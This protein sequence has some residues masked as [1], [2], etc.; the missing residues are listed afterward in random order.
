MAAG[1]PPRKGPSSDSTDPVDDLDNQDT[2][3]STPEMFDDQPSFASSPTRI[4]LPPP[5][6]TR[7]PATVRA[8][9]PAQPI[10]AP[11]QPIVAPAQPIVAPA[12]PVRRSVP[13]LTANV[14]PVFRTDLQMVRNGAGGFDVSDPISGRAYALNAFEVSLARMLNGRR[15]VGDVLEASARLGIPANVESL[16]Q[17]I[18]SLEQCG[19]L[20]AARPLTEDPATPTP[21]PAP[22]DLQWASPRGQWPTGVRN[23]FQNGIRLLRMGKPAEAAGYFEALLQEDSNNVEARELLA[24]ARQ[25]A[26]FTAVAPEGTSRTRGLKRPVMIGGAALLVIAVTVGIVFA[27]NG[28]SSPPVDPTPAPTTPAVALTPTPVTP[29]PVTPTPVTPTPVTPVTPTPVTPTPVTPTPVTPTPVTP[30][31]RVEAPG[32]GE[33]KLLLASAR[34]VHKGDKLF[35][36]VHVTGDPAKT[37]ELTAKVA[38]LE[39]LA[40]QDP[41]YEPFLAKARTDLAAVH[42]VSSTFVVAP[43]SGRA[44]PRVKQGAFVHAGELLAEIE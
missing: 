32:P 16:Q 26:M 42:K 27:L 40:Q 33:I 18:G 14:V 7:P 6:T 22:G 23:L 34:T 11:A 35:E 3:L 29:T 20:G 8:P 2:V 39:K 21:Q 41:I 36:I 30:T 25:A 12:A 44:T 31:V 43:K 19:F 5:P 9:A 24:M 38:D 37:K 4:T 13:D 28:T 1:A 17:F 15:T 10:A